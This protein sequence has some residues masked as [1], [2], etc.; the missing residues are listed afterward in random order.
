[1]IMNDEP[2][3]VMYTCHRCNTIKREVRVRVRGEHEDLMKWMAVVMDE[4]GAA[5]MTH[6]PFCTARS[7]D[8]MIPIKKDANHVGENPEVRA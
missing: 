6:S 4:V 2:F 1:M 5:H 3:N 8:L 7:V